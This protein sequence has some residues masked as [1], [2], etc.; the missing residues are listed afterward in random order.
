MVG[1]GY[2]VDFRTIGFHVFAMK[3]V[4]DAEKEKIFMISDTG[5][6]PRGSKGIVQVSFQM[7]ISIRY[8]R[9]VKVATNNDTFGFS[10]QDS[11]LFALGVLFAVSPSQTTADIGCHFVEI[12]VFFILNKIAVKF[13]VLSRYVVRF[14]VDINHRIR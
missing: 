4:V 8:G 5:T 3:D 2:S 7:M 6:K 13:F 10:V 12:D 9:V 11:C 14:Q 1:I